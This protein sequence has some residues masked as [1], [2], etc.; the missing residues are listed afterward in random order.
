M[1]KTFYWGVFTTLILALWA[2]EDKVKLDIKPGESQ[3]VID[4]WITT[5]PGAK[6][7]ITISRTTPY[8]ENTPEPILRNA[9]V[10]V[11]NQSTGK[12]YNFV[13]GSQG[14]YVY[15]PS[16]TDSLG[17][18]G[19]TFLLTV[20]V[21]GETYRA[22]STVHRV[23]FFNDDSIFVESRP[24]EFSSPAGLFVDF[25]IR[26]LPGLGDFYFLKTYYNGKLRALPQDLTPIS[27]V[28]IFGRTTDPS[29]DGTYFIFPIK[30]RVNRTFCT[31]NCNDRPYKVGDSVT[32]EL[33][34]IPSES[35][36]FWTQVQEQATNVGLLASPPTN[37]PTNIFNINPNGKKAVGFFTAS[38]VSRAGVRIKQENLIIVR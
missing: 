25:K 29:Q 18:V 1:K 20:Q 26:D 7:V 22:T 11:T 4:A 15:Q 21:E 16:P 27:D 5:E 31:E 2:C 36:D 6:Q 19:D 13:E 32:L 10:Q 23:P 17:K 38:A 12:I 8:L 35:Y 3:I 33:L 28:S 14:G 37:V 24:Q 34:S 30:A 9:I